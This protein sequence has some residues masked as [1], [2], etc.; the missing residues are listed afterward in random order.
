MTKRVKKK[1]GPKKQST[2]FTTFIKYLW[3]AILAGIVVL[4]CVFVYI[5]KFEMPN[6][7]ELEQPNFEIATRILAEDKRELG[8][9]FK[10]YRD[11]LQYEEINP[12]IID[13]LVAT[14]DERY[15]SHSGIDARGTLRAFV[16]LGRNGGASTITQQLAKLFFTQRSSSFI[17]RV[18]Q[19]LKEWVIAIE[20]EKQY[21]KEEILAMYLNKY[22]YLYGANGIS[23]AS[24]TYFGKDQSQLEVSE[25]AVLVGLLKN[26]WIYN[27]KKFPDNALSRRAVVMKQMVRNNKLDQATFEELNT[28]PIDMSAFKREENFSGIAPYFKAEL[29]K[30][31]N[32]ILEQESALKPDG[33]KYDLYTDGLVINT[34]IDYDMQRH[35]EA[36]MKKHMKDLQERFF[37]RWKGKDPWKYGANKEQIKQRQ[38]ILNR[39]IRETERFKKMRASYMGSISSEIS[40]SIKNVRL[41]DTDIFRLFAEDKKAGTL[42][43]LVRKKT[44]R[45]DQSKV[46]KEI[47]ASPY[48]PTLKKQWI[49][50]QKAKDKVFK[51]KVK[52]NVFAYTASG[53]KSVEMTPLDSMRYHTMHM[54]LGSIS[55]HPKT[56]YVKTWVGGIGYEYFKYDHI[57][58]N[59]QVGSTFKPF[60]YAT[61]I[62]EQGT[63]PCEKVQDVQQSI[64]AGDKNFGLMKSWSPNNSDNKFSGEYMTLKD[65]LLKSKNSISVY[66]MKE[67]GDTELVRNFASSLGIEKEKI[68]KYPSICLGTPE[69]SVMDMAGSYTTFANDGIYTKPLFITSIEDAN[70]RPIYLGKQERSRA[71]NTGYNYVMVDMLKHASRAIASN[72]K[73][74]IAG[75]T[76]TTNDFKDGWFMGITP[77]LVV[78]TWVGGENEWIRFRDSRDGYGG[79]M[80][81]PFFVEFLK[82]LENDPK[83]NYD[84]S[85]KFL[86]PENQVVQLNCEVYA[87]IEEADRK[88]A[89]LEKESKDDEYD[90]EF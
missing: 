49:D 65:A 36:S 33:T 41:W 17:P 42:A 83:S 77:D 31:V 66:L 43:S 30:E 12:I 51:K 32:K 29:V 20:F 11:W 68:P 78:A 18:W 44:I 79:K 45:K 88:A 27:P 86:V 89:E 63:S 67:I 24:K 90:E 52:M 26:P 46:Y 71:I 80:A 53:H 15:F 82:R 22:D 56:G 37:D 70:G 50:L 2:D 13:A 35:A 14:E 48:W 5:S 38:G 25:A 34:T 58:S 61:A 60:I 81:R 8:K 6:T 57:K 47:L 64:P 76:G 39:Q 59:R 69:L 16:Y 3:A 4:A 21:T 7:E 62:I 85:K 28:T 1:T 9:A 73:S 87:A 19:K 23:A 54:Q 74:E 75:K 40:A 84:S 10:L 72:F 55:V